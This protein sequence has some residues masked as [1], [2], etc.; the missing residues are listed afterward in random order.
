MDRRVGKILEILGRPSGAACHPGS[1]AGSVNLSVSR[2][3]H[4]FKMETGLPLGRF[5][6]AARLARA[7]SLL[8]TSFLSVKQVSSV[9]GFGDE[10]HFIR[11]FK[12]TYGTTPGQYRRDLPA[13]SQE[14][15]RK[16]DK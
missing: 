9:T 7:K 10:T 11:E 14:A 4:V 13:R 8:E 5:L 15:A 2:L 6:R 16:S 12:R 1:L 3:C